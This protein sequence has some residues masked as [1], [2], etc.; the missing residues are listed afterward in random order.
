MSQEQQPRRQQPNQ[1]VDPIKYGDVFN[2]SGEL[3]DQPVAPQD[4]AMMQSAEASIFGQP[5]TGGPGEA[6]QAAAAWNERAGLVGRSDISDAAAIQGVAV[7]ETGVPGG[8]VVTESV[9]GQVVRQFVEAGP[10]RQVQGA[11]VTKVMFGEALEAVAQTVGDKPVDRGDA[12]AIHVVVQMATGV[13]TVL[14]GGI[15]ASAQ[16]AAAYNEATLR[17]EDKIK[18]AHVLM[19]AREKLPRDRAVMGDDVGRVAKAEMTPGLKA[20]VH[21]GGVTAS[22]AAAA[23]LNEGNAR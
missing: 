16:S 2:V 13:D 18:L 5:R 8:R 23:R 21:P 20:S 14:P 9:A 19:G 1:G 22:V 4:A 3:A 15:T 11:V 17:D 12:A 6:M 7:T 10:I